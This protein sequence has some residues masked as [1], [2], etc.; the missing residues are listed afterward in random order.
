[1]S[2]PQ[3][4]YILF[5]GPLSAATELGW[6]RGELAYLKAIGPRALDPNAPR[7]IFD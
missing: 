1:V 4:D 5:E 7:S 2:L 3:R 6:R